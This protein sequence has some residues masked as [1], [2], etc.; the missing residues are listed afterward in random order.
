MFATRNWYVGAR[1]DELRNRPLGRLICGRHTAFFRD[2][3]GRPRA[4]DA[5]CPHRGADLSRGAVVGDAL[6]CPFHGFR[7][8]GAG[9]CIEV[10]SQPGPLENSDGLTVPAYPIVEQQ[11]FVWIWPDAGH[12]PDRA[13]PAYEFFDP[14]SGFRRYQCPVDLYPA[15][16]LNTMENA[17]DGAHLAFVHTGSVPG[18]PPLV[19]RFTLTAYEDGRGYRGEDDLGAAAP[20]YRKRRGQ[21]SWAAGIRHWQRFVQRLARPLLEL[22]PV[23][24]SGFIYELCGMVCFDIHYANGRT[25]YV[26]ALIT[27]ADADSTWF[28]A[29]QVRN[30][31]LNPVGDWVTRNF[32]DTLVGEDR[33]AMRWFLPEARGPG[34]LP[35]PALVRS[36]RTSTPFRRIYAA[37]LRRE[38][39]PVPWAIEG[40]GV[41]DLGH[42]PAAFTDDAEASGREATV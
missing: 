9:R 41:I 2:A 32:M 15:S 13:P 39:K 37:A 31:A 29:E 18:A 42:G 6:Q 3:E 17:L 30:R 5:L 34:G 4:L 28:F 21:H 10:P 38:G 14:A 20:G 22:A 16:Y 24:R 7:Y 1:S 25:D 40:G 26:L 36:D 23:V 33:E 19:G 8:D 12:A 11:G 35:R 27:P